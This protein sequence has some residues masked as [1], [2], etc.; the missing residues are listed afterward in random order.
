M[1]N[2]AVCDQCGC[3]VHYAGCGALPDKELSPAVLEAGA[4]GPFWVRC[5]KCAK[6]VP[7]EADALP[8]EVAVGSPSEPSPV[9]HLERTLRAW[10]I[11]YT[12]GK[13]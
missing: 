2:P 10:G 7:V 3:P 6:S 1:N 5:P 4:T 12:P 11:P 13:P 9:G 8:R